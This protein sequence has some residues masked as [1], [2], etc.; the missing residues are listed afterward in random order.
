[1]I[2]FLYPSSRVHTQLHLLSGHLHSQVLSDPFIDKIWDRSGRRHFAEI[3]QDP[4][5]KKRNIFFSTKT[6]FFT[7]RD[8]SSPVE[9]NNPFRPVDV[10]EK[11]GCFGLLRR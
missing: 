3:Y 11:T 10:F 5:E 8:V 2:A 4:P 7:L 6:F 1:M 9:A